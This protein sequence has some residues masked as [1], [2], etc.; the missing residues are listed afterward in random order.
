[1]GGLQTTDL[2][3]I[4]RINNLQ[5]FA[6]QTK[7]SKALLFRLARVSEIYYVEVTIPKKSGGT[8]RLACPS[9]RMKAVQAWILR[10]ILDH[11]EIHPAAKAFKKKFN[12]CDNIKPHLENRF[13][14]CLDIENF[15]GNIL[16]DS[17]YYIFT[18]L[19]YNNQVAYLLANI[20]TYLG[21]LPQ[22]GVTSPALSNI[23][24]I[25]LDKRLSNF[26]GARNVQYSRYADDSA[27]R[28]RRN[29]TLVA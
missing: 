16:Y 5:D 24:C 26:A 12:V 27:P 7:I 17:V 19:G 14:L 18:S 3:G 25:N 21:A 22:G 13:F 9:K 28:R 29:A 15:F 4:P 10:N 6:F 23:S 1:M 8:R 11:I 20:C 2:L